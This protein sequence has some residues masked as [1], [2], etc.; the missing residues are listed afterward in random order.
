MHDT[1]QVSRHGLIDSM[2]PENRQADNCK[3]MELSQ[4]NHQSALLN[5]SHP[6]LSPVLNHW[7]LLQA[8]IRWKN[9][10]PW[11]NPVS[12][13]PNG[14]L[15]RRLQ[16][17]QLDVLFEYSH[18]LVTEHYGASGMLWSSWSMHDSRWSLP[19]EEDLDF[20][21]SRMLENSPASVRAIIPP[22]NAE[23]F[24]GPHYSRSSLHLS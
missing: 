2:S 1:L 7:S 18:C 11:K 3:V 15:H 24:V 19:V 23:W 20:R 12:T 8:L 22:W 6:V 16:Q 14:L 5:S 21:R 17:N 13:E 9:T 4:Q 10:G